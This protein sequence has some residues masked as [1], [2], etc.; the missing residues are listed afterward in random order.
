[1]VKRILVTTDGSS[2]SFLALPLAAELARAT[3]SEVVLLYVVQSSE[4]KSEREHSPTSAEDV[5]LWQLREAGQQALAAAA[6]LL[7]LLGVSELLLDARH[8]DVATTITQA[9]EEQGADLIVIASHG[10]TDLGQSML[11][12]IAERVLARASMPVLLVKRLR[13]DVHAAAAQ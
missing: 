2:P 6:N 5:Q 11:G 10:S 12:C 4:L 3:R 7:A 8:F 1:M 9:A 13:Q